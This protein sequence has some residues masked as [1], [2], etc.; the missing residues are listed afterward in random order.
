MSRS[1]RMLVAII[2][3]VAGGLLAQSPAEAHRFY[4]FGFGYPVFYRAPV[5]YVPPPP[6]VFVVPRVAY[7]VPPPVVYGY[8]YRR[9]VHHHRHHVHH[10]AVHH[11]CTCYCCR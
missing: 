11:Y 7:V 6:P 9:V 1:A 5:Y 8:G 2:V 10:A 4:R 3:L